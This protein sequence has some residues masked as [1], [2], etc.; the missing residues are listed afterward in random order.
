MN[1]RQMMIWIKKNVAPIVQKAIEETGEKYFTEDDLCAICYR[2]VNNLLFR[3]V[4]TNMQFEVLCSLMKGDYSKRDADKEKIYHGFSFWQID[5]GTNLDFIKSGEW[6]N[7]LKACKK[8]LQ[9]LNGKKKVFDQLYSGE[10]LQRIIF[11][12]YN[13]GEGNVK[14]ALRKSAEGKLFAHNNE[15]LT[16]E[17][18]CDYYTHERNY[19][20]KVMQYKTTYKSII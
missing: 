3:F 20:Q 6:K 9:I 11:A 14:K 17:K 13:C 8:A 16:F 7:P 19:S 4:P 2:E 5:I 15:P 10:Q 12:S 1:E 18:V